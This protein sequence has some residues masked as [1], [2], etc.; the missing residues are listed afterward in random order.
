MGKQKNKALSWMPR[1]VTA[2]E[3]DR[4]A[5]EY[6]RRFD[7]YY[8][9]MLDVYL[10]RFEWH[11]LPDSVDPRYA[12]LALITTGKAIYFEE[13][14]I[15]PVILKTSGGTDLNQ[16][17]VPI[18]RDAYSDSTKYMEANL[19]DENSVVIFNNYSRLPSDGDLR[20]YASQLAQLD[21]SI[22][23]NLNAQKTPLFIN[24]KNTN[25]ALTMKNLYAKYDGNIPIVFADNE[26]SPD[27]IKVMK[28]DAPFLATE[29]YDMKMRIWEEFLTLAGVANAEPKKER[30]ITNEMEAMLGSVRASR[31]SPLAARNDA[32][33]QINKLFGEDIYVTFRGEGME[34]KDQP[35]DIPDFADDNK[36]EDSKEGDG[37]E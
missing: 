15:G 36:I 33:K 17:G 7:Y 26:I 28:T 1:G 6:T 27:T 32:C 37:N 13:P 25:Q 4:S 30:L 23:M 11:N 18:E 24:V 21:V 9:R 22:S 5:Y 20:H 8:N 19:N 34:D 10:S 2:R 12:E 3:Q 35:Y 14:V 31:Y 16:Y 29:L